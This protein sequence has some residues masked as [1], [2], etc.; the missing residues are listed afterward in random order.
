MQSNIITFASLKQDFTCKNVHVSQKLANIFNLRRNSTYP[1]ISSIFYL[2]ILLST[3]SASTR[4][5][6]RKGIRN[7][8]N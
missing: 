4:L 1:D 3:F 8:K 2:A 7:V 6:G 5:G